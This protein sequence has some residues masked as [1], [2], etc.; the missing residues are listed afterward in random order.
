MPIQSTD[1]RMGSVTGV[2]AESSVSG[3]MTFDQHLA[4]ADSVTLSQADAAK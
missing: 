2:A 4:I 1:S 3:G